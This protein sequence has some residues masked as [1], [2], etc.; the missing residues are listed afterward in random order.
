MQYHLFKLNFLSF[1]L[2]QIYQLLTQT[3]P[4]AFKLNFLLILK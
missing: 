1:L 4:Y 2:L 3:I